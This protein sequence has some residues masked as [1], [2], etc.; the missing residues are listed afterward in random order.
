M[1]T[2]APA[3]AYAC[4]VCRRLHWHEKEAE[5]CCRCDS[6]STKLTA[7]PRYGSTRATCDHCIYG[8]QL[9]EAR[10]EVRR[11]E[12]SLKRAKDR[13]EDMLRQGRPEK[14]EL[15]RGS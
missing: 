3:E 13:L 12:E 4:A 1:K 8:S 9:R 15:T 7:Q 14:G 6:C 11:S 2:C 10:K 5:A